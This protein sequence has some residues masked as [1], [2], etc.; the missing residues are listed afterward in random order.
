[1]PKDL[2]EKDIFPR[3]EQRPTQVV[4]RREGH[5]RFVNMNFQTGMLK[6]DGAT[7]FYLST[8]FGIVLASQQNPAR[9][10]KRGNPGDYLVFNPGGFYDIITERDFKDQFPSFTPIVG[11]SAVTGFTGYSPAGGMG[12]G[13]Y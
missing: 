5:W 10:Y 9:M 6:P 11:G 12:G 3:Y 1:M 7:Y 13:G 2:R 4:E 8:Q